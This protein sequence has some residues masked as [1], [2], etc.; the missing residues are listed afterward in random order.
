MNLLERLYAVGRF[1]EARAL[2]VAI[3]IARG[4]S[5]ESGGAMKPATTTVREWANAGGHAP[6]RLLSDRR[7]SHR[8]AQ[9]PASCRVRS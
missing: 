2:N 4:G 9:F 1:D 8:K 3:G 6:I 7:G 5:V